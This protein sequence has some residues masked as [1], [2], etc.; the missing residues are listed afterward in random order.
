[1][2]LGKKKTEGEDV[3]SVCKTGPCKNLVQITK[4]NLA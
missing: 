4:T 2:T 1:M 3:C